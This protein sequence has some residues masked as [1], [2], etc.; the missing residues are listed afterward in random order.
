MCW[1]NYPRVVG[2]VFPSAPD[3]FLLC[4]YLLGRGSLTSEGK[5]ENQWE[6]HQ[7]GLASVASP[8]ALSL[9][10]ARMSKKLL[11]NST[12]EKWWPQRC[13]GRKPVVARVSS[14]IML[15]AVKSWLCHFLAQASFLTSPRLGFLMLN[16]QIVVGTA[17][18][19]Q[20]IEWDSTT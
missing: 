13:A 3:Q 5:P 8:T 19:A 2:P 10:L 17:H 20:R 6:N 15:P 12:Q 18:L 11:S 14:G 16:T 7:R 1:I 4:Q 9:V